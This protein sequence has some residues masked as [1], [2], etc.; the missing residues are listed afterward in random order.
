[1]V[2]NLQ[3]QIENE[4]ISFFFYQQRLLYITEKFFYCKTKLSIKRNQGN[5]L[6]FNIF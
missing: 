6:N 1:M 4:I 2:Y 3:L 5:L